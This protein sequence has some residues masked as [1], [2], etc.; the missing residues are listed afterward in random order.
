M[1]SKAASSLARPHN[2]SSKPAGKKRTSISQSFVTELKVVFA[3]A[4]EK[5]HAANLEVLSD[6]RS[7][8]EQLTAAIATRPLTKETSDALTLRRRD[9]MLDELRGSSGALDESYTALAAQ[10]EA[11]RVAWTKNGALISSTALARSWGLSR[12]GLMEAEA[13]H[14]L[15]FLKIG[16]RLWTPMVFSEL[17]RDAVKAVCAEMPQADSE[18][19]FFFWT[20][21]HGGLRGKT[22]AQAIQGGQLA[23]VIEIARGLAEENG[24][25]HAAQV[26]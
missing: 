26:A 17:P 2:R 7:S 21:T 24:W 14:E 22:V 13:R 8:V 19:Q 18:S 23:R 11:A 15:F 3:E 6:I 12:Q 16:G 5:S 10:G 20:R 9:A 1:A 4:L 25:A